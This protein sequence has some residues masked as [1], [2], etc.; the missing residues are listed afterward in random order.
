[1]AAMT[2]KFFSSVD[3]PVD[4]LGP[5]PTRESDPGISHARPPTWTDPSPDAPVLAIQMSDSGMLR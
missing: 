3:G 2:G 5:I 4:S 1:M